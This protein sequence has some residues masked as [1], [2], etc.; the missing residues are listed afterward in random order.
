MLGSIP[1]PSSHPPYSSPRFTHILLC[2]RTLIPLTSTPPFTS[3]LSSSSPSPLAHTPA[4][5]PYPLPS[6][7]RPPSL[8]PTG[9]PKDQLLGT[10]NPHLPINPLNSSS[11]PGTTLTKILSP[12]H[13]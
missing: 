5:T 8:N 1:F 11:L 7:S 10:P 13:A 12:I 4:P 6:P 9:T 3:S 2:P